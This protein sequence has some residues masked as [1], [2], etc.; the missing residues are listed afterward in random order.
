WINNGQGNGDTETGA[1]TLD[2]G[3]PEP[4][5]GLTVTR[6]TGARVFL[7]TVDEW[8]KAAFYN[9]S[10]GT[11]FKYATGSDTLPSPLPPGVQSNSA[12]WNNAVGHPTDVGAYVN[13][14]SPYGTF[15]QAGNLFQWTESILE[16]SVLGGGPPLEFRIIRGAA[17]EFD[18][19]NFLTSNL[20]L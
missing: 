4:T 16:E 14:P 10:T 1:Y 12:N 19:P 5:N 11:Y 15:D 8:N 3:T 9:P 6:N 2:G 17:W 7:P 20:M 13:S 18:S